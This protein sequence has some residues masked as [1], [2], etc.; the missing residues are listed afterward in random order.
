[1]YEGLLSYLVAG[2]EGDKEREDLGIAQGS[3]AH[4]P[5]A[6]VLEAA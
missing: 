4:G 3:W 5:D 2:R 1:M 6:G